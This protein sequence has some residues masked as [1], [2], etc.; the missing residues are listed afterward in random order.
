ML[1]VASLVLLL[2]TLSPGLASA[3]TGGWTITRTPSSVTEGFATGVSLTAT[4]TS[5]GSSIGCIRL[6]LPGAFSV[7]AVAVDSAPH[8]WTADPPSGGPSGST[9]VWVH[10]VTEADIVK[11]DGDSRHLPRSGHRDARRRLCV[12]G[13][14]A[15]PCELHI[16]H[17]YRLRHGPRH[18]RY[19][20]ANLDA[21]TTADADPDAA[22]DPNAVADARADT[23]ANT[24]SATHPNAVADAFA[25]PDTGPHGTPERDR[26]SQ[27]GPS[28]RR[29]RHN[30]SQ[31]GSQLDVDALG[32]GRVRAPSAAPLP[33]QHPARTDRRSGRGRIGSASALAQ[34]R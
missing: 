23:C 16:G 28:G 24:D 27:S 25:D 8:D 19:A 20:N 22:T 30:E 34:S 31:P 3:A 26:D 33:D 6:Q 5:G 13:G 4:N 18:C 14:V 1:L 17:R 7:S 9:L 29:A 21:E 10:A 2:L 32:F 12:A 15:G 11:S